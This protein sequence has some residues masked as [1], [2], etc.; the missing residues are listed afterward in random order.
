ALVREFG[1]Q[2]FW[3]KDVADPEKGNSYSDWILV[4]TNQAFLKDPFVNF[5]IAPWR[6]LEEI[7]WTDDY[8]NLFQVVAP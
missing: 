8:S 3:I 5:R 1:K 7:L 4:T 6:S 2:A